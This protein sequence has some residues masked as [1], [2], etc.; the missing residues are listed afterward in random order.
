MIRIGREI[1]CLPYAGFLPYV[2]CAELMVISK[3]LFPKYKFP[4]LG[5]YPAVRSHISQSGAQCTVA[6]ELCTVNFLHWTVQVEYS[7]VDTLHS[8]I[9]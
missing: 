4:N 8:V 5:K 7:A 3:F 1:Q 2:H 6:Y 9:Q